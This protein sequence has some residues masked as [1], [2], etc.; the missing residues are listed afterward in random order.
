MKR[1][2]EKVLEYMRTQESSGDTWYTTQELSEALTMQRTNLSRILN[3]LVKEKLVR[4]TN[5]RPVYYALEKEREQSCFRAMIGCDGSLKQAVQMLKAAILYPG[6]PM[7]VLI[8]G[9]DGSGKS[10]LAQLIYEFACEQNIIAENQ[11]H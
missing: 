6:H 4:I 5:G 9:E 7:P 3:E 10:M 1:I 8:K 11:C 2:R